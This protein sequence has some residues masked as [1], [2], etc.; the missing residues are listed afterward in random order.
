MIC[1]RATIYGTVCDGRYDV[2]SWIVSTKRSQ[3]VIIFR[4]ICENITALM[5]MAGGKLSDVLRV[6]VYVTDREVRRWAYPVIQE[7][8]GEVW[9][10]GSGIVVKGL[11]R[12][13]LLVEID[14][15]GFIDDPD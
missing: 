10:C 15:Y 2:V 6:V 12:E 3:R 1:D 8:V 13:E 14:A 7:Y 9:P 11:A 5:E 4:E